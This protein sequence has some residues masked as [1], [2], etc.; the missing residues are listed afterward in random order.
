M[1]SMVKTVHKHVTPNVMVVT[2]LTVF[3]IEDVNLAG[4]DTIVNNVMYLDNT[5]FII[6]LYWN[7]H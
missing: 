5:V 6:W 3:V 1:V 2:T 7:G 4:W